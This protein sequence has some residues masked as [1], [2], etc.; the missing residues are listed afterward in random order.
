M[1]K[2]PGELKREVK[3]T[4]IKTKRTK[5]SPVVET[6]AGEAEAI[7]A[8]VG[9]K[10][11]IEVAVAEAGAETKASQETLTISIYGTTIHNKLTA[12]EGHPQRIEGRRPDED[13]VNAVV[14]AVLPAGA[15]AEEATVTTSR[16]AIRMVTITIRRASL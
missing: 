4:L 9:A 6:M 12:I 3:V 2:I 5:K 7:G 8:E 10:T 15:A 13:G 16:E 1:R 11:T 14:G